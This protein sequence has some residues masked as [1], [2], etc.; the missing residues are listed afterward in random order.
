[1][2]TFRCAWIALALG[3]TAAVGVD[4]QPAAS[5]LLRI[6]GVVSGRASGS[7]VAGARI[8]IDEAVGERY[9]PG[10]EIA[11]A[12]SDA[13]GRYR[14]EIPGRPVERVMRIQVDAEGHA[15]SA[16]LFRVR[17]G[18]SGTHSELDLPL[19]SG[20]VCQGRVFDRDGRPLERAEIVIRR[21]VLWA[22]ERLDLSDEVGIA[23]AD[24]NGDFRCP[25]LMPG[26]H[27]VEIRH[28][29]ASFVIPRR[30][31]IGNGACE[32]HPSDAEPE[33]DEPAAGEEDGERRSVLLRG[34]VVDERG[35]A[36]P[37]GFL[38]CAGFFDLDMFAGLSRGE[39]P[40]LICGLDGSFERRFHVAYEGIR[41]LVFHPTR[42]VGQSKT[43]RAEGTPEPPP[44]EIRL[45]A[46][47]RI[48][49]RVTGPDGRSVAGAKIAARRARDESVRAAIRELADFQPLAL[50]WSGSDGSYELP[51]VPVQPTA[52]EVSASGYWGGSM[53]FTL[54]TGVE[55]GEPIDFRLV[56]GGTLQG[57]VLDSAGKPVEVQLELKSVLGSHC[58]RT[59]PEGRFSVDGLPQ[60]TRVVWVRVDGS[61]GERVWTSL[62]VDGKP[63]ELRV[64]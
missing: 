64:P 33:E 39:N 36:A 1:M 44:F 21:H 53:R 23:R 14:V 40:R 17:P 28:R 12:T 50:A 7:P 5:A 27:R 25:G 38:L 35:R 2:A 58:I 31:L 26:E 42:G 61:S 24:E 4:A 48:F 56:S 37:G 6:E 54:M 63:V 29:R 41:I 49:G 22:D 20:F 34:R 9:A 18:E 60:G 43:L 46:T 30:L 45:T 62:A 10:A 8:R 55:A 52:I 57:R 15:A 32:F 51:A 16:R 3:M 11:R 59:D 47:R 13:R 19:L